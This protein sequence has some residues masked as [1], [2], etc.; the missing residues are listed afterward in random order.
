MTIDWITW[1]IWTVGLIVLLVWLFHA[2]QE[3][4]VIL[5]EHIKIDTTDSLSRDD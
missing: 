3:V 4:R 2:V 5:R 1:S